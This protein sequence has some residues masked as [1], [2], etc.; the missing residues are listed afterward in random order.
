MTLNSL[1]NQYGYI[2]PLVSVALGWLS[3]YIPQWMTGK[4]MQQISNSHALNPL[5]PPGW[6]FGVVW[7]ILYALMGTALALILKSDPSATRSIII[8]IFVV[9][10]LLN[11]AWTAIYYYNSLS[12]S[13]WATTGLAALVLLLLISLLIG[14]YVFIGNMTE[15]ARK[16]NLAA[17]CIV[18]YLVWTTFASALHWNNV[19]LNPGK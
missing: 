19:F 18:P 6:V 17:M 1:V 16:Y 10:A 4:D 14:S 12:K 9:Q 11:F 8:G 5:Q 2:F 15:P 3:G 13:V 7:T